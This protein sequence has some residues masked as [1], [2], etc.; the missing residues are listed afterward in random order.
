[1]YEFQDVELEDNHEEFMFE[2]VRLL[3]S[4]R[5]AH[6]ITCYYVLPGFCFKVQEPEAIKSA[7]V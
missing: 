5:V 4:I 3:L 6:L 1:M 7:K 2:T